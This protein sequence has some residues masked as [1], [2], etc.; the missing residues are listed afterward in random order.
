M[1]T[2]YNSLQKT[3][4]EHTAPEQA[5]RGTV[6]HKSDLATAASPTSRGAATI[7]TGSPTA[8]SALGSIGDSGSTFAAVPRQLQLPVPGAR[9]LCIAA[10]WSHTLLLTG[11]KKWLSGTFTVVCNTGPT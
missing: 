2:Q 9:V 11:N 5:N 1:Y 4:Q 3:L 6:V 10:G 7:Q 8:A